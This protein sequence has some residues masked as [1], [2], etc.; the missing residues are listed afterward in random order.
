MTSFVDFGH[1]LN[2]SHQD[3]SK[4]S[5]RLYEIGDQMA[6]N[7]AVLLAVEV[8][9][10]E[11]IW[12]EQQG[13]ETWPLMFKAAQSFVRQYLER[14]KNRNIVVFA[15]TGDVSRK[16]SDFN[17]GNLRPNVGVGLRFLL[18]KKENLNNLCTVVE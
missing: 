6:K 7:H 11:R 14:L 18:D 15:G 17:I 10:Y 3:C 4:M 9:K 8:K 2:Q 16:V 12:A 1:D 13:G 5:N